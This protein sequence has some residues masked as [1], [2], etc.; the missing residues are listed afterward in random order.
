MALSGGRSNGW[1]SLVNLKVAI[2]IACIALVAWFSAAFAFDNK[3]VFLPGETSV[4]HYLF[5][6]SCSSCHEG[7]KPVTNDTCMRYLLGELSSSDDG[8]L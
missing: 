8:G 2:I 1:R 3:Q 7:F 4:G 5:E 6:T